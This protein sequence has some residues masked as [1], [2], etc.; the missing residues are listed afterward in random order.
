MFLVV[1]AQK[2]VTNTLA[3]RLINNNI[4]K[5]KLKLKFFIYILALL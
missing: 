4:Y 2:C 3:E 5:I 1:T